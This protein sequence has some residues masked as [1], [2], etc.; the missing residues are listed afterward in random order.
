MEKH[1]LD[2][3]RSPSNSSNKLKELS[4]L[5]INN[6]REFTTQA[7]YNTYVKQYLQFVDHHRLPLDA[8]NTVVLFVTNWFCRNKSYSGC[9]MAKFAVIAYL[10]DNYNIGDI[11]WNQLEK[12]LISIKRNAAIPSRIQRT[13]VPVNLLKLMVKQ[14]DTQKCPKLLHDAALVAIGLRTMGRGS[15]LTN[16]KWNNIITKND[17]SVTIVFERTKTRK[18]GRSVLIK[19][20]ISK[21]CPV[22]LLQKLRAL[23]CYDWVFGGNTKL[24]CSN[25]SRI[26]QTRAKQFG[27]QGHFTSHSLRIGGASAL[28]FAG[29]SKEKIQ[30]VGDWTSDA[31]DRYMRESIDHHQN[32]S[33]DMKL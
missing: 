8:E 18:N 24:N 14:L 21:S 23:G 20:T 26:L 2:I 9:R 13:P 32:V 5:L 11:K 28:T 3:L 29:Y 30:A 16:L 31:V 17:G 15:E 10:K 1:R 6:S 27:V 4:Q 25:I 22:Y 33:E 12:L 7:T 19:P